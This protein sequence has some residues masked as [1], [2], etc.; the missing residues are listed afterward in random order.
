MAAE[1]EAMAP[2]AAA[3]APAELVTVMEEAAMAEGV[4][5]LV[6]VIGQPEAARAA[7]LGAR[8]AVAEA[9]AT[10]EAATATG[11]VVMGRADTVV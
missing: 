6:L 4:E 7:A 9:R 5:V 10:V 1:A 3:T 8:A 2:V 11:E